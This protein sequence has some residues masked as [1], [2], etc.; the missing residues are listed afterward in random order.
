MKSKF[1]LQKP[2]TSFLRLASVELHCKEHI[3]NG[4]LSILNKL[5]IVGPS[6]ASHMV[7]DIFRFRTNICHFIKA[8]R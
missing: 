4:L 8:I 6:A 1:E 2:N 7:F 3:Q 5:L